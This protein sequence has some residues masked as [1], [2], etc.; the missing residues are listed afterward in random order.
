M[1]PYNGGCFGDIDS[2][3][4]IIKKMQKSVVGGRN[5]DFGMNIGKVEPGGGGYGHDSGDV[6]VPKKY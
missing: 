5:D 6:G 4:L 2:N 3:L 1:P